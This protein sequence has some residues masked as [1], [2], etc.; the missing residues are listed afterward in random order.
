MSYPTF[1]QYAILPASSLAL[2]RDTISRFIARTSNY[3]LEQNAIQTVSFLPCLLL[4]FKDSVTIN[5]PI[6][7]ESQSLGL[8]L[9][10]NV[11]FQAQNGSEPYFLSDNAQTYALI[12]LFSCKSESW[13]LDFYMQYSPPF[14]PSHAFKTCMFYVL[15]INEYRKLC[16]T[17]R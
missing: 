3:H 4:I 8:L 15:L 14:S 13:G 16:K 1:D 6:V 2:L 17:Y 5:T 12:C 9:C 10:W 7:S 11:K